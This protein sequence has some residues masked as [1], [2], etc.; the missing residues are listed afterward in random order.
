MI[1][2][3]T[4]A[5]TDSH[6]TK[7][8]EH[9]FPGDGLEA[10]AV[11]LCSR[12]PGNRLRMLVK[13]VILVPHSGCSARY[14][15]SIA[16]PGLVLEGA[17]DQAGED[18][19]SL[20][21][22]HSHPGGSIDF[23]E[24]DDES[25]MH[26][27]PCLFAGHGDFH[28]SAI[29]VEDGRINARF[30]T[31]DLKIIKVDLVSVI[32]DRLGFYFSDCLSLMGRPMACSEAMTNELNR[33]VACV[34]GVSGTGS[35]VA[36][37]L[38]RLG[39]SR[40]ILIDFDHVEQKN[41]NRILNSTIED[42]EK[43]RAK[44][45]VLALAIGG[46]RGGGVA[47]PICSDIGSREAVLAA[48]ECDI[49]FSCTDTRESR[50]IADRIC[51]SFLIPLFDVG[52]SIETRKTERG[53]EIVEICGRIDYIRPDG[54]SLQDRGVYSP[55][56]LREEYLRQHAQ[57]T[58]AAEVDAGYIKG[59]IENSPAVIALN[60]RAAASCVLEFMARAYPFRQA[61]DIN[62][63]SVRFFL[64]EG[65][66]VRYSEVDFPRADKGQFASGMREPLLGL[67][68]LSKPIRSRQ[69]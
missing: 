3:V 47:V 67:P 50:H 46:Y 2:N 35:I 65:D 56:S 20:V 32:G 11:L 51:E 24:I 31:S 63:A 12:T 4:L 18:G 57:S 55:S 21:L 23:S 58:Y 25:D 39:F 69:G 16:W 53:P 54:S 52:V 38:A 6:H 49:L 66:E 68:V 22:V 62:F 61:E 33:L 9:L 27:M 44:V 60:M 10:A 30:Y 17:L 1:S 40:V 29:M 36:E 19:L 15:D 13:D 41:L 37:Q 5:L 59:V 42:A 43:R 8:R 26:V 28:G 48:S 14:A 7:V 45:D 34:I 64:S